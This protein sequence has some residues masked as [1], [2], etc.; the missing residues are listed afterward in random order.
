M[1]QVISKK[2]NPFLRGLKF[3]LMAL[4]GVIGV[5]A[6]AVLF[7]Y[8]VMLLWNWLMPSIFGLGQITFWQ[9]VGIVILA[10]LIFG[11]FKHHGHDHHANSN[12]H[13]KFVDRFFNDKITHHKNRGTDWKLF[14][15]YWKERG[16]EDFKSYVE[17]QKQK[18]E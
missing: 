18:E 7:G 13:P 12:K 14:G 4:I 1:E 6:L 8:F 3:V 9:A 5:G 11:G 15:K 2:K 16:E 10:R 17:E